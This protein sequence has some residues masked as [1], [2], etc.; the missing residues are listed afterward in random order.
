MRKGTGI[1]LALVVCLLL[2]ACTLGESGQ[3]TQGGNEGAQDFFDGD[4]PMPG[5]DADNRYMLW[6]GISC[7]ETGNYFF[8]T[9]LGG[10]YLH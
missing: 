1:L 6:E 2:T 4:A 3:D 8:G 10:E 5:L 9:V 7:Q